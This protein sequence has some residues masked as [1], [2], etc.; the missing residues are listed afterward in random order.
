MSAQ[1]F[2]IKLKKELLK[3]ENTQREVTY[4][5]LDPEVKIDKIPP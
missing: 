5:V 4:L 1:F 2:Y 3:A